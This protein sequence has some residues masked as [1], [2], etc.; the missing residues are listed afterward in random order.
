MP[1]AKRLCVSDEECESRVEK[2]RE[3]VR[4]HDLGALLVYSG[5]KA[6]MWY[7]TGHVAYLTNWANLDFFADAIV[8]VPETGEAA[9]LC[10]GARIF[11][12]DDLAGFVDARRPPRRLARPQGHL[13]D[14]RRGHGGRRFGPR[15]RK[16]RPGDRPAPGRARHRRQT[17]RRSWDREHAGAGPPRA[18]GPPRRA[19][20]RDRRHR[21]APALRQERGPRSASSATSSRS[22][23]ERSAPSPTS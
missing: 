7:Q 15:R 5:P 4:E 16:L 6:H 18:G 22:A 14:L 17:H 10:P 2:V 19:L 21:R 8:V 1:A 13:D 11:A 9:L 20:D 23:T 3:F 12:R